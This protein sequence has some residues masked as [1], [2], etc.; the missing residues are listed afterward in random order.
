MVNECSALN[1]TF[2][3]RFREQ[4]VREDRRQEEGLS[5]PCPRQDIATETTKSLLPWIPALTLPK[6]EPTD[7]QSS[8]QRA[9][10]GSM[11]TAGRSATDTFREWRTTALS[12]EP[13]DDVTRPQQF[14][15]KSHKDGPS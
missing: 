11:L 9:S 2:P 15:S 13:T 5:M 8:L 7:S 12:S 10:G 1:M 3:L 6:T 4:C 14:Q